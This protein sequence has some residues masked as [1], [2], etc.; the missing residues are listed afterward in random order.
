MRPCVRVLVLAALL[1]WGPASL[2]GYVANY[3]PAVNDR[4]IPGNAANPTFLGA[5][6]DF[7]GVSTSRGV[8]LI[9]PHF[10]ITVA[11]IY[12]DT[13]GNYVQPGPASF[14]TASGK[15]VTVNVV[16]GEALLYKNVPGQPD[17]SGQPDIYIGM[18]DPTADMTDINPLPI[19]TDTTA[20]ALQGSP[21]FLYGFNT[22]PYQ[23][24]V[25][26]T[27]VVDQNGTTGGNPRGVFTAEIPYRDM[28]YRSVDY[29]YTYNPGGP[30]DGTHY[31]YYP[32]GGD[33]GYANLV[34]TTSGTQLGLLGLTEATSDPYNVE[35]GDFSYSVALYPYIS[36]IKA[37]IADLETKYNNDPSHSGSPMPDEV[38]KVQVA[39][40]NPSLVPVPEP[41]AVLLLL[42][43]TVA[44]VCG[45]VARRG[46]RR[47]RFS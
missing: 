45:T 23:L 21:F 30:P 19:I 15:N 42:A 8:N 46:S 27:N 35:P 31:E 37:T 11:H 18:L 10:Y 2:A 1:G 4:F 39:T 24:Q 26:G 12:Y 16:G 7:S 6:Y 3:N 36:Q 40:A 41:A 20:P 5:G 25:L 28:T 43:G 29:S 32:T 33:S 47:T 38:A 9:A 44:G 22:S 34:P 17:L 13:N 14:V